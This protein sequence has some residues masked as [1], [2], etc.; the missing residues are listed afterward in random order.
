MIPPQN[1]ATL[2][3]VDQESFSNTIWSTPNF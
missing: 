2:N 1:I 3:I